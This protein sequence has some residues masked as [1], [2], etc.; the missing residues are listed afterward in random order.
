[1]LGFIYI[2]N[3]V[4]RTSSGVLRRFLP[5]PTSPI[6]SWLNDDIVISMIRL[7]S[8]D[9]SRVHVVDSQTTHIAHERDDGTLLGYS[10]DDDDLVLCLAII[11]AIGVL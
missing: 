5:N 8:A 3:S 6:N 9:F 2:I 10:P 7:F 11:I 1:M 4:S